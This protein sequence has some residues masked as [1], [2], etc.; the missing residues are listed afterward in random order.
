MMR[1]E[2][3]AESPDA[4][5]AALEGWRREIVDALRRAVAAAGAPEER[6]KWGHIVCFSNGPVLLI[7][8][9][10][11][12][13]LFG[14]WRGKRLCQIEPRLKPGGKYE[15]ATMTFLEGDRV[16]AVIAETL[17]RAAIALN[18]EVGDPTRAS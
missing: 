15:L 7:R 16:D 12:R 13:V 1:K 6:I 8:A 3:P 17:V 9:E 4:Y 5:V 14:F 18:A 10:A 2:K 11:A